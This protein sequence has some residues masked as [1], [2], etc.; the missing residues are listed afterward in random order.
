MFLNEGLI[1][2]IEF[3]QSFEMLKEIDTKDTPFFALTKYLKGILWTG[4]KVLLNGLKTKKF[5]S[6]IT[7]SELS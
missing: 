6:I 1:P 3:L 4:D 5:K 7:T 2:E